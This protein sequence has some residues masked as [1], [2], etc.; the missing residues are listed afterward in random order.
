[1]KPGVILLLTVHK[2]SK[3]YLPRGE[4]SEYQTLLYNL[5]NKNLKFVK[6]KI[7]SHIGVLFISLQGNLFVFPINSLIRKK[8]HLNNEIVIKMQMILL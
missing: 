5:F 7:F 8:I 6:N 4:N 3:D 2:T 1:M